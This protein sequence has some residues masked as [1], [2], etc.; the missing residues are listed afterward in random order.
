MQTVKVKR[1][2]MKPHPLQN[3]TCKEEDYRLCGDAA[4]WLSVV[5]TWFLDGLQDR[6]TGQAAAPSQ[7]TELLCDPRG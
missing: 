6:A 7:Q 1:S 3:V 2:S 5:E 4:V